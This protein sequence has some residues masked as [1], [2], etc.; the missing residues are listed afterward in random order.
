[1]DGLSCYFRR[2]SVLVQNLSVASTEK[3]I[4]RSVA[5]Q[6]TLSLFYVSICVDTDRGINLSH[7][8]CRNAL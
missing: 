3:V 4:P 8:A 1:M 5:P 7:W 2:F 6:P